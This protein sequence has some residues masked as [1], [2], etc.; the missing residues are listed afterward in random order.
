MIAFFKKCFLVL[1]FLSSG[2]IANAIEKPTVMVLPDDNWLKENDFLT[3]VEKQGKKKRVQH[4]EEAFIESS[5]LKNVIVTINKLFSDRNF[6]LVDAEEALS[7][8]S[9][10]ELIDEFT[11]SE[12]NGAG[13]DG[14]INDVLLRNLKPDY[15]LYVGWNVND[16]GF[17]RCITYRMEI[18]DAYTRESV[19]AANGTGPLKK[20][21]VPIDVLLEQ[22]VLDKIDG[23]CELLNNHRR[24]ILTNGRW[25]NLRVDCWANS[26]ISMSTEYGGTELSTIL[27]N[28]ISDNSV[29]HKFSPGRSGIKF[30]QYKVRIPLKDPNGRPMVAEQF[31]NQLRDYLKTNYSIRSANRTTGIGDG[32]IILGSK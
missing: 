22:S 31:V 11:T 8:F 18:K 9:D 3:Y 16:V 7:Q 19:A 4:Y 5:E 12:E 10:D 24:D 21:S 30:R 27:Y 1:V 17:D 28:W 20:R 23:L 6:N 32:R 13:I 2:I 14:D 26:G 25:I 29:N 15:T